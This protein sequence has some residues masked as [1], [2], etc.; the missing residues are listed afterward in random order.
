[1][2]PRKGKERRVDIKPLEIPKRREKTPERR[3]SP[4][5]RREMQPA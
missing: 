3:E 4:T 2:A 1:M 5:R